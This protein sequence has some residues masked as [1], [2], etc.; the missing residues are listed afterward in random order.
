MSRSSIRTQVDLQPFHTL[1]CPSIAEYAVTLTDDSVLDSALT[2]AKEQG[3]AVQVIGE[4]S[5][6]VPLDYVPGLTMIN[7]LSGVRLVGQTNEHIDVRV[8]GGVSWHWLVLFCS[9]QGWYGLENLALIPGTVGAAPVQ[10]I[11][12][13]GVELC[14]V[15]LQL[16]A[17]DI[18]TGTRRTF[19][20]ADCQFGYRASVFKGKD[21]GRWIITAVT[22]RLSRFF[23]P[24]LSY[25]PLAT[26]Q[27]KTSAQLIQSVIEVRQSKLPNPALIPNAGSFFTNPIIQLEQ[28]QALQQDYP[29]LPLY[30]TADG[31]HAK[32]AAG[33]LIEQ[34]GL[35]GAYAPD[36][37][38]GPYEKQALVLINPQRMAASLVMSRAQEIADAVHAKFG[39]AITPE[40]RF[41]P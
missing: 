8:S 33:W 9:A 30:P 1:A 3:M 27:P 19:N 18:H 5:N 25:G 38:I 7:R 28:A 34:A 41:F 21:A 35:R 15:F 16:E 12:A 26:L 37:G 40:P 6:I 39:I 22:L 11:G 36:T 14:D 20:S 29:A 13:Y 31:K 23:Q 32:V 2:W 24:N 4:G 10:N 17:V